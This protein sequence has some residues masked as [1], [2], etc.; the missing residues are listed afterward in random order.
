MQIERPPRLR[1][2]AGQAFAAKWLD[3]D[4]GTDHVAIDVNIADM[5]LRRDEIDGLVDPAM[6]AQRQ[7]IAQ[8]IDPVDQT[9]QLVAAEAQNMHH[10]PEHFRRQISQRIDLDQGRR[11]EG[12]GF[13]RGRKR[14]LKNSPPPR[15]HALDMRQQR[16]LCRRID[17]RPDIGLQTARI[18]DHLLLQGGF[19]KRQRPLG[20]V[21]L[22]AEYA[23]G[24][25]TLAGAIEAGAQHILHDLLGQSR[26]VHDHR[27]LAA[28][29]GD[30]ADL[31]TRCDGLVDQA[32]HL[33]RTGKHDPAHPG[34]GR[35]GG[36][37][38]FTRPRQALQRGRR[39]PRGPHQFD[40]TVSN[41]R[42]LLG[43]FGNNGTPRGQGGAH[44]ADKNGQ[45]KIP[46]ADAHRD[47][48]RRAGRRQFAAQQLGG[49][50]AAEIDRFADF[51]HRIG[52]GLAGFT[53]AQ[54][55]QGQTL[56]LE[57][58]GH[59]Q[60]AG[61]AL[62]RRGGIPTVDG[63]KSGTQCKVDRRRVGH[64]HLTDDI[65]P[66]RRIAHGQAC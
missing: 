7:A 9:G 4:H 17:D 40:G 19:Q 56:R 3:T 66:L 61:S 37:H 24:R 23:Q 45:R 1:P 65:V 36:A 13:A 2:R 12:T 10:R 30:Q 28:G 31:G 49:V 25:A 18:A 46:G 50:I 8:L 62:A 21:G 52:P 47:T 54:A 39:N 38:R 60:Q 33:G 26:G 51:R 55:D 20:N 6:H 64:D 59:A 58:I 27:I 32:S 53:D 15:P 42:R 22:Q 43:R 35:Q 63:R 14:Q 57:G 34:I 5:R 16:R 44:F 29:F 48:R 11:H 41:Q